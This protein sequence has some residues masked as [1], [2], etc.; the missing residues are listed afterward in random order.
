MQGGTLLKICDF[1]CAC[2][3]KTMMTVNKGSVCWISPEVISN[4]NYNE[5]CDCYSYAVILFEI[6]SRQKP[7]FH[8]P[9]ANSNQIMFNVV[10]G[11]F[12][13]KRIKNC[14]IVLDLLLERGLDGDPKKRPSMQMILNI[15]EKLNTQINKTPVRPLIDLNSYSTSSD[16][17]SSDARS[18]HSILST[19]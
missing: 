2:N 10:L 4:E 6:L 3:V 16:S 18:E 14:P 8:L 7:Y 12:R 1:G 19:Q 17:S 15:M 5:K 9:H 11:K 13:P